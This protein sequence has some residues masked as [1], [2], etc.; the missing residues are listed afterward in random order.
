MDF[1]NKKFVIMACLFSA[2][3]SSF[4]ISYSFSQ[5]SIDDVAEKMYST[6]GLTTIKVSGEGRETV[7]RDMTRLSVNIVT[8]PS[9]IS[10]LEES[11]KSQID[12]IVN[13]VYDAL[14]KENVTITTGY[15]YY[16]PQWSGSKPDMDTISAHVEFPIKTEIKNISTVTKIVSE[17]GFFVNNLQINKVPKSNDGPLA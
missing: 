1:S 2:L 8:K 17:E 7:P 9:E 16:N 12:E 3:L 10:S 14:G 4:L 11:R 15:T 6:S 13:S 5:S